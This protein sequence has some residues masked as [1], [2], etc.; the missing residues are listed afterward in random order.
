[1]PRKGGKSISPKKREKKATTDVEIPSHDGSELVED[2]ENSSNESEKVVVD[3][4]RVMVMGDGKAS[5]EDPRHS[6]PSDSRE[7]IMDEIGRMVSD[8]S[9]STMYASSFL[10]AAMEVQETS[11]PKIIV[12][13]LVTVQDMIRN[14]RL[15]KEE[16]LKAIA[17]IHTFNET[18]THQAA[19]FASE[20]DKLS[21]ELSNN[22]LSPASIGEFFVQAD[23]TSLLNG[24]L[25]SIPGRRAFELLFADLFKNTPLGSAECLHL[26]ADGILAKKMSRFLKVIKARAEAPLQGG[27]FILLVMMRQPK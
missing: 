26:G 22:Q 14:G 25:Q 20:L 7:I 23:G 13:S 3:S 24:G 18:T 2:H 5:E 4:R 6:E 21:A 15:T 12:E 11:S 17:I 8:I 27:L 10:E 1:M 19:K 16:Y 9:D